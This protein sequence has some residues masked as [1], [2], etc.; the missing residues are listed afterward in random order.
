MTSHM[1]AQTQQS[2]AQLT[3]TGLLPI[4]FVMSYL[5]QPLQCAVKCLELQPPSRRHHQLEHQC[6]VVGLAPHHNAHCQSIVAADVSC[7]IFVM[8]QLACPSVHYQSC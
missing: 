1:A 5:L 6:P 3:A 2:L 8:Q 7:L 4:L